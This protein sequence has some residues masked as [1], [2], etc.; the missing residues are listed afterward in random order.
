MCYCDQGTPGRLIMKAYQC[1]TVCV[2]CTAFYTLYV[3]FN[4]RK[5]EH[6]KTLT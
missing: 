6:I 1:S 3:N 5:C 4:Y 2:V